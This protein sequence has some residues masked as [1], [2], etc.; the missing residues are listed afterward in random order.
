MIASL[1]AGAVSFLYYADRLY[2]L[3]L[4]IVGIAIGVVLLPDCRASSAPATWPA[5]HESQNRSLEFGLMLTL[6]AAIGLGH[7]RPAD[8]FGAVRARRIHRVRYNCDR[9]GPGRLLRGTAGIRPDQGLPA[10]V[11]RP[12]GHPHADV[13]RRSISMIVN[14][15]LLAHTLFY[16]FSAIGL[17]PHVGIALATSAAG[18]VNAIL[19]WLSLDA[20]GTT[21]PGTAK[22]AA[23]P[24]D[25]RGCERADG[26]CALVCH[27][28]SGAD[29][30]GDGSSW[31]ACRRAS[32]SWWPSAPASFFGM[33]MLTGT[34]RAS[35]IDRRLSPRQPMA[36]EAMPV[37]HERCQHAPC[38][39]VHRRA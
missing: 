32:R 2:Q 37:P 12:R 8:H 24:A 26:P 28:R 10:G 27:G 29:D 9:L 1:Q 7:C 19:L 15:V 14:V 38:A 33:L 34:F 5:V 4:G 3:P 31:R 21:S 11:L 13:V 6:P 22:L 39:M 17:M 18:W 16:W 25:Y 23:K 35:P 30:G 20:H 36:V